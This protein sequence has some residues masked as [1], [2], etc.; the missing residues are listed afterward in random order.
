MWGQEEEAAFQTLKDFLTSPPILGYPDFKLPFELHVDASASGLGAV[1]YQ[2]QEGQQR[3]L[4]YAS[5]GLSKAEKNYPAHKLEFLALKW[6]V[7]EKFHDYLYGHKFSVKTDNNPLTYVLT[8]ARLDATGHRWLAALASYSFDITYRPGSSNAD[9][10]ALSRLPEHHIEAESVQAI[11][12]SLQ[13]PAYA[14]CIACSATVVEESFAAGQGLR[15]LSCSDIRQA[16]L[17]DPVLS[18][19]ITAIEQ[20]K[21]PRQERQPNGPHRAL[22]QEFNKLTMKKGV[23]HRR[24]TVGEQEKEQ[25]VVPSRYIRTVLECLHNDAGH[26][27][28]DRTLSLIRDRFFWP[29]MTADV[30]D[31]IK[32]C[33]R[34]VRRKTLGTERAPLVSIVTTEPLELVCMDYLSLETSKGGYQHI[35]VITDHFT[36][37]AQAIPTRNMT[38][39]TTADALVNNFIVHYG[40]PKR[41]HS[42]Q[43]ANFESRIIRELCQIIGCS[44]SRTTPYHPMGNGMCERFNRTLLDMLGTLEPRQKENWKSHVASLVHAYNCTRHESTG[45]SPYSL[46]FGRDPHLPVDLLFGVDSN[47]QGREPLTKYVDSLKKRLTESFHLA[48]AASNK[49]SERQKMKIKNSEE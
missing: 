34:C 15:A 9:A 1:L 42:D 40:V 14:E 19:W 4:C 24:V 46:M 5:R 45:F 6:A 8:S 29:G 33:P 20:R 38:A 35:L 27:G 44:K 37:L 21:G 36:R 30:E 25:L 23:L 10:D 48:A 16:Q 26:P 43:G 17:Q 32:K 12:G 3:A 11:C 39:K 41:L 47:D 7:T 22:Q 18:V 31:W 28:R 49:A 13:T 2:E